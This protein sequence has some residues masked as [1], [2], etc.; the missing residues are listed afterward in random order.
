VLHS[1]DDYTTNLPLEDLQRDD[2][3]L[4]HRVDGR[5]LSVEHG[6]PVRMMIPHRYFWKSAKWIQAI[7]FHTED[8]PGFWETRGYHNEADP[9][10]EERYGRKP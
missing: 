6:G 2:V 5:A 1:A 10:R 3:L 4:A 9:W 7:R 8:R